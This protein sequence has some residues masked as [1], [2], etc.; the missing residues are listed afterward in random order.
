M[1]K[2][3]APIRARPNQDFEGACLKPRR[4]ILVWKGKIGRAKLEAH[5]SLLA[6]IELD[7]GE[8]PQLQ[9]RPCHRSRDIADE[10]EGGFLARCWPPVFNL[11]LDRK[12]RLRPERF[13]IH[14]KLRQANR[15]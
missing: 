2:Q 5:R 7:S 10:E 1:A 8:P 4:S 6:R 11:R 9:Q 3:A 14:R 12:P 13:G 15:G